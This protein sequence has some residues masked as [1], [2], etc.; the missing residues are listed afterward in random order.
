M[1]DHRARRFKAIISPFRAGVW[2]SIMGEYNPLHA[3]VS[4]NHFSFAHN[5]RLLLWQVYRRL[6]YSQDETHAAIA[7]LDRT[8]VLSQ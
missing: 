7:D 2:G 6:T 1:P 8:A 5:E 4:E 3:G